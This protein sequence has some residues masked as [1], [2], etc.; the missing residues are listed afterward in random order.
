MPLRHPAAREI[1][2]AVQAPKGELGVFLVSDEPARPTSARSV[3]GICHLQAMDFRCKGYLL[4]DGSANLGSLDIVR[5]G[6]P[7]SPAFRRYG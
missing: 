6:R 7:L 4:A 5:R 1:Y 3:A 2:V